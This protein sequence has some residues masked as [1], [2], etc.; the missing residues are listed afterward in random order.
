MV[1]KIFRFLLPVYRYR[2]LDVATLTP[3]SGLC[4]HQRRANFLQ[5]A[6]GYALYWF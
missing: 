1:L 4:G 5:S 6:E 2:Y 3:S